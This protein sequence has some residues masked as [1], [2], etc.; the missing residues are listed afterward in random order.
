[1]EMKQYLIK[2]IFSMVVAIVLLITFYII[3]MADLATPGET[4]ITPLILIIIAIVCLAIFAELVKIEY[5][6]KGKLKK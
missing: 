3:L 1:M 6:I 2:Q 5:Y 4:F